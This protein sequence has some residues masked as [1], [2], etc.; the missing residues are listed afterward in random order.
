MSQAGAAVPPRHHFGVAQLVVDQGVPVAEVA[1]RFRCSRPTVRCWADRYR[2]G[3]PMT[4]RSSRL[5]FSPRKT[6]SEVTRRIVSLRL[7]NRLGPAQLA[8]L[9]GFAPS[10]AHRVLVRCRPNRL[11][12]CDRATGEPVR[13]YEHPQPGDL[14]RVYVKKLG[15]IPDGGGWRFVARPQG[16]RNR[17]TTPGKA[18]TCHRNPK[19]GHACSATTA[20]A[21]SPES[22]MT[23]AENWTS[24]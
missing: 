21:M 23:S 3:E 22:G 6:S 2:A 10:T 18:R 12:Y 8:A 13:R 19:M 16:H 20:P 24:P 17:T 11:S 14:L 5:R 7:R 4:D 9:C 15:Q 1:A